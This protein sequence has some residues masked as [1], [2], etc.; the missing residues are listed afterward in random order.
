LTIEGAPQEVR[1]MN[2]PGDPL[3]L[4]AALE[5]S[6]RSLQPA[7][8]VAIAA[9]ATACLEADGG[10]PWGATDD[11]VQEH[12]LPA[13]P[14]ASIGAFEMDGRLVACTALK[15]THTPEKYRITTVGQVHPACRRRGLGTF[16]LNWSIAEASKLLA[17][18]P[19]DRPHVMQLTTE[20]LTEAAVGL[21]ER[22]GFTR[23]SPED[24]LRRDLGTS[25]PNV[26][27]PPGLRFE[28]WVPA[29]ADQFFAVYHAAF[30]E[31]PG[32][33][34][35][36]Q[37]EWL[38]WTGVGEDEFR[39]ELS[40]LASCGDLP[41]GFITCGDGWQRG[42][43]AIIQL[44]VRP[45]WRGQGIG[46]ALL[47]ETLRRFQAAGGDHVLLDVNVD[48]PRAARVYARL[49]FERD[50]RRAKYVLSLVRPGGA[51]REELMS[52]SF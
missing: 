42:E 52:R 43:V 14:G 48:N 10:L 47:V 33:P 13:G 6:W 1:D 12:Y 28:M 37:E 18:C 2:S 30:R 25:L 21:Y 40:L 31:R 38:A 22:H 49:G 9:L 51:A 44:G 29:L 24:V 17:A 11:Y 41:V 36:G 27:L 32:Y 19:P 15:P 45:E 3:P 46:S 20:S 8:V 16:L 7:D 4:L 34:N 39:P 23:Q 35:W 5:L 26:P 50:G